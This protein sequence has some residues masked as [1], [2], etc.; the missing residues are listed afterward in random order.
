MDSSFPKKGDE[1]NKISIDVINDDQALAAEFEK[2]TDAEESG[3][4]V[5]KYDLE[6]DT[7]SKKNSIGEAFDILSPNS[8]QVTSRAE[9][10]IE[11]DAFIDKQISELKKKKKKERSRKA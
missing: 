5:G 11:N 7:F 1:D 6:T 3:A 8:S 2:M 9:K 4:L 10:R